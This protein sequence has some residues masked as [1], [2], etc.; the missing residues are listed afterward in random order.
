MKTKDNIL[1]S[2]NLAESCKL[3]LHVEHR[4]YIVPG[5]MFPVCA[6]PKID[7]RGFV[8]KNELYHLKSLAKKVELV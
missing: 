2:G 6:M 5:A 4:F 3:K 8:D 7:F 1:E